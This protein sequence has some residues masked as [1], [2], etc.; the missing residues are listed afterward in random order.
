[1]LNIKRA[2]RLPNA[3]KQINKHASMP[4]SPHSTDL[5]EFENDYL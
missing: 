3:P 2:N 5:S 4:D 1:M